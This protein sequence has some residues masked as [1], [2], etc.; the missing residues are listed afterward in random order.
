M[1][2]LTSG[3][4]RGQFALES[5][6]PTPLLIDSSGIVLNRPN[7]FGPMLNPVTLL[8]LSPDGRTLAAVLNGTLRLWDLEGQ[9]EL[10]RVD[11]ARRVEA[12]ARRDQ[13]NLYSALPLSWPT[14]RHAVLCPRRE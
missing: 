1:W 11:E 13:S 3:R 5:S 4:E 7:V 10:R 6:A 9:R 8:A 14:L 12:R 2:E